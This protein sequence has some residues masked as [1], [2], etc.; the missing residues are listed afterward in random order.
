[1]S[2]FDTMEQFDNVIYSLYNFYSSIV[3]KLSS[4][5]YV[6]KNYQF[7]NKYKNKRCFILGNGPSL[8]VSDLKKIQ[9]EYTFCVNYFYK[10]QLSNYINPSF[11]VLYDGNFYDKNIK[12]FIE[13]KTK[14]DKSI[15]FMRD[16]A[17]IKY[18]HEFLKL[19][20]IFYQHA[21]HFQNGDKCNIDLTKNISA[22]VN[23][24]V[25][26]IQIALYMGFSEIYLLGCDFNSFASR[27][28]LHFYKDTAEKT[29][30]LADEL[31]FYSLVAKHHYS[32][33]KLSKEIGSK[34]INLT[35]NS[36]LDAYE[37]GNINDLELEKKFDNHEC[38]K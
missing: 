34:I 6:S 2:K 28:E 29:I 15:F 21:K 7:K 36:L 3:F 19:D 17:L 10:S 35:K 24:V 31:K 8:N 12:D 9:N 16:N 20:N 38:T 5:K 14:Y 22:P 32:L 33:E 30:S 4:H 13:C 27:E 23:V 25:A 11:Y 26:A 1:M 37:F 18:K